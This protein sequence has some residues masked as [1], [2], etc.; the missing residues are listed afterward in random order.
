MRCVVA[1]EPTTERTS[2]RLDASRGRA[3]R[4]LIPLVSL[5]LALLPLAAVAVQQFGAVTPRDGPARAS[6]DDSTSARESPGGDLEAVAPPLDYKTRHIYDRNGNLAELQIPFGAGG[7]WTR[8]RYTYGP[9]DELLERRREIEPFDAE[10]RWT[11]EI[12]EYDAT[13][14]LVR[15]TDPMGHVVE[16]DYD[17]R[18]LLEETRSGLGFEALSE[19]IVTRQV[20]SLDR[21]PEVYVDGR[22]N[23]WQTEYDGYGRRKLSRDPE[24]NRSETEYDNNGNPTVVRAFG[25]ASGGGTG[26]AGGEPS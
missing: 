3:R 1:P 25:P 5:A 21:E 9:L 11:E 26:A 2:H 12:R 22:G 24:G 18:D 17:E 23:S 16:M 14:N 6:I 20:Y 10:S 13:L 4:S 19:P 15:I 7:E 8:E